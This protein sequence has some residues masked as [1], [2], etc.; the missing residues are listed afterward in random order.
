MSLEEVNDFLQSVCIVRVDYNLIEI[1]IDASA[2]EY[3]LYR[4]P[5]SLEEVTFSIEVH[6]N[7]RAW[8]FRC[9]LVC[10]DDELVAWITAL[11][12][13]YFFNFKSSHSVVSSIVPL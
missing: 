1:S 11:A 8:S 4:C 10:R 13:E 7:E 6:G 12:Y 2:S 3:V 5:Y 9:F